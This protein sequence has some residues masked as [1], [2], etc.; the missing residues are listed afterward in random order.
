M[1]WNADRW[2]CRIVLGLLVAL[3]SVDEYNCN[4]KYF[5]S[6]FKTAL[7]LSSLEHERRIEQPAGNSI[8]NLGS[9]LA[10]Q[11][12]PIRS[13]RE[14][15]IRLVRDGRDLLFATPVKCSWPN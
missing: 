15:R 7:W 6:P 9:V 8:D 4:G 3:L 11:S 2:R 10:Q 1:A 12:S 13:R 5:L 14:S